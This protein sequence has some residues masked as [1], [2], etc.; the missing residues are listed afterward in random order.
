VATSGGGARRDGTCPKY[1]RIADVLSTLLAILW[2]DALHLS[3]RHP[4]AEHVELVLNADQAARLMHRLADV[5][6]R[7]VSA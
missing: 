5:L 2:H 1:S 3:R 4:D 6:D 7:E